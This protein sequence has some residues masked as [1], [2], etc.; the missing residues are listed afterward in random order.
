MRNLECRMRLRVVRI[1]AFES[2]V[3]GVAGL[4]ILWIES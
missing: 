4:N 2:R 3:Y 1:G